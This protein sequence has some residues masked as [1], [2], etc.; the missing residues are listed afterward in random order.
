MQDEATTDQR[1]GIVRVHVERTLVACQRL[2]EALQRVQDQ[3]AI[4]Q[5]CWVVR[6]QFE[7]AVKTRQRFLEAQRVQSTS[8]IGVRLGVVWLYLERAVIAS[9][10]RFL[11]TKPRL[12]ESK[13]V[14]RIE[15]I[16]LGGHD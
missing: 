5:R 12:H 3:P 16:R 6:S 14:K 8:T 2:F 10:C 15:K 11:F 1:F 13:K 7:G 4:V 9:K